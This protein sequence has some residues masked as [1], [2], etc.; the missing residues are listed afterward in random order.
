MFKF[1]VFSCFSAC[2][3]IYIYIYIYIY[4]HALRHK[5]LIIEDH[6]YHTCNLLLL[7][8][9]LL[10]KYIYI[11]I[12]IYI[13]HKVIRWRKWH[14]GRWFCCINSVVSVI[15]KGW[16][17]N[18]KIVR[19]TGGIWRKDKEE[20]L[21]RNVNVDNL[22]SH[23]LH[24][25]PW[26]SFAI[27]LHYSSSLSGPLNY[28]IS[29]HRTDVIKYLLVSQYWCVHLQKFRNVGQGVRPCFSHAQVGKL[30][31]HRHW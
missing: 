4:V 3:Y 28:I 2:V 31:F 20:T 23:R 6:Y 13:V 1:R 30:W 5:K 16:C 25:F 26:L 8:L 11:Y 7:L 9:L 22:K 18:K 15:A 12:Y 14:Y 10:L 17:A 21:L 29:Q 24:G 19:E 27:R